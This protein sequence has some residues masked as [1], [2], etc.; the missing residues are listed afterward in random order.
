MYGN[1]MKHTEYV[2]KCKEGNV[3]GNIKQHKEYVWSSKE[4]QGICMEI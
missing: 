4:I 3:Y 1:I 2:W